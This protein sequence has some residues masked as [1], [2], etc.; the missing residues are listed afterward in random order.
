MICFPR[1]T[2]ACILYH[3]FFFLSRGFSNFFELF[4]S[5]SMF[6]TLSTC[7]LSIIPHLFSFVNLFYKK[8][9]NAPYRTDKTHFF[10]IIYDWYPN[11]TPFTRCCVFYCAVSPYMIRDFLYPGKQNRCIPVFIPY[12]YVLH[13]QSAS[14]R[15]YPHS[16]F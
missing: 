3:S 14:V 2:T 1:L 10:I 7:D 5:N 13:M 6:P 12:I 4:L 15:S 8:L 16:D 11:K 9:E